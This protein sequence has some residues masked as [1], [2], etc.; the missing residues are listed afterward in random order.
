MFLGSLC[1]ED[2]EALQNWTIFVNDPATDSER[3]SD[4][5]RLELMNLGSKFRARLP[6]LLDLSYDPEDFL[7]S[8]LRIFINFQS[9]FFISCHFHKFKHTGKQRTEASADSFALGCFPEDTV[10]TTEDKPT[11]RVPAQICKI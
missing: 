1:H 11:I 4:S 7:V 5:G 8:M 3:L 2:V 9:F 6:G 10:P